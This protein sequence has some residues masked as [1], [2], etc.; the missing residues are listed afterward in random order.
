MLVPDKIDFREKKI[1]RGFRF[2]EKEKKYH[3]HNIIFREHVIS[4]AYHY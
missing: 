1:T 4:M 3:S 2:W